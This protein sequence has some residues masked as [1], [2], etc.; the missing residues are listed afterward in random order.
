VVLVSTALS[1]CIVCIEDPFG[2][3]T[4]GRMATLHVYARDYYTQMPI[5][6]AEVDLY[7][8]VWW[9]WD[10]QG[11]WPVNQGGYVTVPCGYLYRDGCGGDEEEDFRV[12]VHA[13]GYC[14]E[15]YDIELS[16]YYSS[17]TLTFYL[18]PCG[19]KAAGGG[20]PVTPQEA[21]EQSMSGPADGPSGKVVTGSQEQTEGE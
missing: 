9:D 2:C 7:E 8:R 18:V 13:P 16:Y 4:A 3:G 19:A 5:S 6:W 10:Y 17:E 21:L 20:R 14:S 15:R 12:V 11:T 1:G